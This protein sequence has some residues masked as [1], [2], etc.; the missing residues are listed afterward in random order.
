MSWLN[1]LTVIVNLFKELFGIFNKLSE[2]D[3]A[4]I[5]DGIVYAYEKIFK[6]FFEQYFASKQK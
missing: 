2:E 6:K 1:L 4:K 5:V 3:K